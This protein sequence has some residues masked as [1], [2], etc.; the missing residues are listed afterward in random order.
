MG[1]LQ[2][3]SISRLDVANNGFTEGFGYATVTHRGPV[4]ATVVAAHCHSRS[5]S[6]I[7]IHFYKDHPSTLFCI[8]QQ[9]ILE[10]LSHGRK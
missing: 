4:I 9:K 8:A 7:A 5:T 6:I 3:A 1:N 2:K 10:F